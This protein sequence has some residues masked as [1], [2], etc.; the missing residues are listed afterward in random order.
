MSAEA[1]FWAWQQGVKSTHKLVL[2]SLAN[3]HNEANGQC[4]P[5]VLYIANATGLDRKTVMTAMS[6]LEDLGLIV[7]IKSTGSSTNYTLNLGFITSTKNGTGTKNG[8]VPKTD[9]TSTKNGTRPVPKTVPKSK[10]NLKEP[11]NIN[12]GFDFSSWPTDPNS[13]V[14]ND[15]KKV[16]KAPLTQSAVDLMAKELHLAAEHGFSVDHCLKVCAL[17]A[18]RGF[19]CEWLLNHEGKSQQANNQP[20]QYKTAQEKRAER[21]AQI[22]DYDRQMAHLEGL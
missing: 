16:R 5:S 20:A 19:Q 15:W 11:K 12:T 14:L 7:R 9:K 10:K 17:R 8:P 3:C 2:L 22:F 4:N 18:W 1:T 6:Q 21:N 13:D